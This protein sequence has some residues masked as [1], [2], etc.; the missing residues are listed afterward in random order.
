[1]ALRSELGLLLGACL[2]NIRIALQRE[3]SDSNSNFHC[4]LHVNSKILF[5]L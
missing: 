4:D 1:M 5:H 2:G 3:K